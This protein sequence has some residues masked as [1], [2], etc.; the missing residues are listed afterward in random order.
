[1]TGTRAFLLG[2]LLAAAPLAA[3]AQTDP[4]AVSSVAAPRAGDRVVGAADAPVTLTAYVSTT[5]SHCADWHNTALPAIMA[6]YVDTGQMRIV[7]RDLPTPPRDIA[8]AGAVMARCVPA[9]LFDEALDSLFRGQAD[10]H[11]HDEEELKQKTTAWLAAAGER[12]GLTRDQMNACFAD[13]ANWTAL[14]ARIEA[15]RAD[16]VTGTPTFFIDGRR[17]AV[18]D[19]TTVDAVV[20]PLLAAR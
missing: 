15:S 17:A 13:D 5:C 20:Q 10:L 18:W 14:D 7:Y 11:S 4:V 9:D 8:S 3:A 1:M 6:K 2:L 16:G 12:G 19:V